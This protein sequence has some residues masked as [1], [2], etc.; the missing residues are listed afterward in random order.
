MYVLIT[1]YARRKT[2]KTATFM[3]NSALLNN[4]FS[5]KNDTAIPTP[6]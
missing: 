4:I 2:K 5:S 3:Q 6:L 1:Q